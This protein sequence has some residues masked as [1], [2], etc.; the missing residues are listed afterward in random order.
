MGDLWWTKWYWDRFFSD[1]FGFPL[2]ISF[3][4]S[5][6]TLRMNNRPTGGGDK[7]YLHINYNKTVM[8]QYE[9]RQQCQISI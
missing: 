5:F 9:P 1:F 8:L 2:S 7:S 3:H 6:N 4:L